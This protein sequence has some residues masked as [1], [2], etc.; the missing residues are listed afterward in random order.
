MKITSFSEKQLQILSFI[1]DERQYLICDGAVRSGKTIVM[2][3][4]FIVWA[5]ENFNKTNFAICSKTV[6]NAE[7]NIVKP[8]RQIEDLPYKIKY[9][10]ASRMLTINCGNKENYFYCFGGKDESSYSLIQGITLAGILL[11]EVVL[12]PRSFVEQ[13]MARTITFKN[14][15]IWFNCNPESP[16]HWFYQEWIL[17]SKKKEV[18]HLHF[19]MN[20]NPIIGEEEITQTKHMYSGVFHDRYIKGLWIVAEGLVYQNFNKEK[21]VIDFQEMINS[22]DYEQKSHFDRTVRYYVSCDYGITNP[23]A[24]YVWCIYNKNAYCIKEY[25]QDSRKTNNRKTDEEHYT[26]IEDMIGDLI[27]EDFVIDPSASSFKEVIARHGK[28]DVL[29]AKNDVLNGISNSTTLLD[30]GHILID[31]NCTHFI[32]EFGLYRW[33]SKSEKDEVM[34]EFDH[35]MDQFRYFVQSIL[36]NEFDWFDWSN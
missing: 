10:I 23:F 19:L 30:S 24:C 8:L 25:Y 16:R 7:R 27:I 20:D 18:K 6:A 15:K 21:H 4:A 35:A 29:N 12:M 17:K 36:R 1:N 26:S 11:D 28:Y 32:E 3:I 31:K 34:K 2:I 22:M 13:A 5:M 9:N 33:D 14:R